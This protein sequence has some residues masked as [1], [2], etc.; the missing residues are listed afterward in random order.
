MNMTLKQWFMEKSAHGSIRPRLIIAPVLAI[1][2]IWAWLDS[3]PKEARRLLCFLFLGVVIMIFDVFAI[4][5]SLRQS[6][7]LKRTG[8]DARATKI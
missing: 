4:S 2:A 6:G 7:D 1:L 5:K 3:G 8:E